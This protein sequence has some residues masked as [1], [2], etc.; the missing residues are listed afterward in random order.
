[1]SFLIQFLRITLTK[2]MAGFFLFS[3]F[4]CFAQGILQSFLF[5]LDSQYSSFILSVLNQANA[6]VHTEIPYLSRSHGTFVL[7]L[8]S[9]IP[10]GKKSP[11]TTIV[12][13]SSNSSQI[14]EPDVR[15]FLNY[16]CKFSS[17]MSQDW[18][19]FSK[20]L[21]ILQISPLTSISFVQNICRCLE[22]S[23]RLGRT[24]FPSNL[25]VMRLVISQAS[26]CPGT[27]KIPCS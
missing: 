2:Y 6:P 21:G 7:Q 11:C 12:M 25:S 27:G 26:R 1:M 14:V 16:I 22:M 15:F 19:P 18:N 13:T 24:P 17:Q 20:Q 23:C 4:F 3:F 10:D 9:H 5:N 8:C